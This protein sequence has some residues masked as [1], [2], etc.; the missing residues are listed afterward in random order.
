MRNAIGSDIERL[1][2]RW[3]GAQDWGV[4]RGGALGG[5]GAGIL[6]PDRSWREPTGVAKTGKGVFSLAC[7][8][9]AQ[10][11]PLFNLG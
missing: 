3:S 6:H 1:A 2:R 5:G 7:C 4:T 11:R 9:M 10:D 8:L